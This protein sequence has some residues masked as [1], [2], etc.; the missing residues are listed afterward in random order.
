MQSNTDTNTSKG[1]TGSVI[2]CDVKHACPA[3]GCQNAVMKIVK[4]TDNKPSYDICSEEL[5][6]HDA[7]RRKMRLSIGKKGD[8]IL[9]RHFFLA[10]EGTKCTEGHGG[11]TMVQ[12]TCETARFKDLARYL[13]HLSPQAIH[14]EAAYHEVLRHL[15][16]SVIDNVAALHEIDFVHADL[17]P[18]NIVVCYNKF[19]SEANANQIKRV[20]EHT[21]TRLIDFGMSYERPKDCE[22]IEPGPLQGTGEYISPMLFRTISGTIHRDTVEDALRHTLDSNQTGPAAIPYN[23]LPCYTK[24]FH[25]DLFA[26]GVILNK[27]G[28]RKAAMNLI[29]MVPDRW[30]ESTEENLLARAR[31]E[32]T[33]EVPDTTP[34][35][36][37]AG[38]IRIKRVTDYFYLIHRDN[39]HLADKKAIEMAKRKAKEREMALT[40]GQGG[41]SA[42][43]KAKIAWIAALSVF[44][45]ASALVPRVSR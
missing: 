30:D 17:K 7:I 3:S 20:L 39:M 45:A 25:A 31:D 23:E 40:A 8:E 19:P 37:E 5:A 36:V 22:S 2:P 15:A 11:H 1:R 29:Q 35:K 28:F 16:L 38:K 13:E 34:K 12:C 41:G 10:P 24:K 4:D 6:V 33:V 43:R 44:T 14:D 26:V 18:E 27:M 42:G 32:V 9:K 21:K